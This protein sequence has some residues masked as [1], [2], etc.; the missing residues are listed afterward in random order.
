MPY[1]K[2]KPFDPS[3]IRLGSA[4]VTS[5]GFKEAQMIQIGLWID[6]IVTDPTNTA[7]QA[8]T[9][10]AVKALCSQFPAPGLEH[11]M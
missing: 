8:E 7:L 5:R 11:L 2:R 1:D 4:A 3:G 9:A 6:A 10:A